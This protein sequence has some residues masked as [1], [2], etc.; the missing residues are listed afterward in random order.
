MLATLLVIGK[1]SACAQGTFPVP[2]GS[3]VRVTATSLVAPL[4]A[5]F[6]NTRGDTAVFIED[7]AGRGVWSIPIA[8]ISKLERSNGEKR[9]NRDYVTRGALY[10]GGGGLTLGLLFASTATPSSGKKY[11]RPITGLL[12]AA[13]G[14]GIG[15]AVGTRFATERWTAVSLARRLSVAPERRGVGLRAA[16]D[17]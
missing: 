7:A 8:E 10:G 15:A 4:V 11:S 5:N 13:I 16:F 3:R 9:S 6:L 2:A 17:F 12:G 1:S 14:A